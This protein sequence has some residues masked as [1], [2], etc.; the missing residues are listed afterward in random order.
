MVD[1]LLEDL[2]ETDEHVLMALNP[3]SKDQ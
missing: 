1:M 3:K 2:V